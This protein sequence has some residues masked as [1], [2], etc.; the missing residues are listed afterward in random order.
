MKWYEEN[1]GNNDEAR[2]Y[3]GEPKLEKFSLSKYVVYY[4]YIARSTCYNKK[5][6]IMKVIQIYILYEKII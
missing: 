4:V 1:E 3:L 2:Q 6:Y 5:I